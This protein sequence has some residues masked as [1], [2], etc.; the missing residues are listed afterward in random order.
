MESFPNP[1]RDALRKVIVA[2]SHSGT[3]YQPFESFLVTYL[4]H[5]SLLTPTELIILQD[6]LKSSKIVVKGLDQAFYHSPFYTE[7]SRKLS[8]RYKANLAATST[9]LHRK[10]YFSSIAPP[11]IR[12]LRDG[13]TI[14]DSNYSLTEFVDEPESINYHFTCINC[15][16]QVINGLSL[17]SKGCF[18][19]KGTRVGAPSNLAYT[20]QQEMWTC[21]NTL[22]VS[23][24]SGRRGENPH[25]TI[26]CKES[27][28]WNDQAI[29]IKSKTTMNG[30]TSGFALFKGRLRISFLTYMYYF[31]M[32]LLG[33]VSV[34]ELVTMM[35]SVIHLEPIDFNLYQM[36]VAKLV[37]FEESVKRRLKK[38][39]TVVPS[40]VSN[41]LDHIAPVN[42]DFFHQVTY[43]PSFTM[44]EGHSDYADIKETLIHSNFRELIYKIQA[45]EY[46][47]NDDMRLATFSILYGLVSTDTGMGNEPCFLRGFLDTTGKTHF[48]QTSEAIEHKVYYYP[49]M[50]IIIE[51]VTE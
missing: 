47:L 6:L 32:K 16:R 22:V 18:S 29:Q 14:L 49:Q 44:T 36:D 5:L 20:P 1:F 41:T 31:Q 17:G 2:L 11:K 21:C 23:S 7:D 3:P 45:K 51:R 33:K 37:L 39:D 4:H 34:E 13:S 28:H 8:S 35:R 38:R 27:D 10:T 12:V 48:D 46:E 9:P 42:S 26:G 50:D 15:G 24:S 30:V 40:S 43:D 25:F 19:H